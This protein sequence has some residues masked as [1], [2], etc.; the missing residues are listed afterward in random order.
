M[1]SAVVLVNLGTPEQP[2]AAAIRRFLRRFLSDPRVVEVP[3]P[4]WLLILYLFILP[5]RPLA[6]RSRY[7]GIF[8]DG[9]SPLNYYGKRLE[10]ALSS[11]LQGEQGGDAPLVTTAMSYS[12]PL[13]ENK[14]DELVAQGFEK[15]LFIPL[16]PQYSATTTAAVHDQISAKMARLRDIPQ[17]YWVRD[18]HDN[19]IYLDALA[20]MV[21]EH[22]EVQGSGEC[23]VMS[24]HGIP[25]RNVDLGDPYQRHCETTAAAIAQRLGLQ[26]CEWRI[27]YQSR[28]GRAK[29]LTPYMQDTLAELAADGV[30]HIDVICPSFA[31]DCLETLEEIRVE[32]AEEFVEAGGKQLNYIACMNDSAAHVALL[33]DLIERTNFQR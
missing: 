19:E 30:Q 8:I 24:F 5:F 21:R 28:L 6:L 31:V 4:I 16:Y 32:L 23:L 7:A 2:T 11:Q 20:Q 25:Q 17:W 13:L 27:A 9:E 15:L 29:W 33:Q 18:Y 22:R 10:S 3:R 1:K 12:P 14:I 26:Q